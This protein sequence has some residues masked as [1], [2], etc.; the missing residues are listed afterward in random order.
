RGPG[1]FPAGPVNFPR[2]PGKRQPFTP[3]HG[4]LCAPP[5]PFSPPLPLFPAL[6]GRWTV[7]AEA[8]IGRVPAV[9]GS[10]WPGGWRMWRRPVVALMA[11]VG[12]LAV[13]CGSATPAFHPGGANPAGSAGAASPAP[14]GLAQTASRKVTWPPFGHDIHIV[15][16]GWLPTDRGQ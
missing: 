15:M 3:P 8:I 9:R 7:A 12:A 5:L 10:R 16:P 6:A 13:A 4:S 2:R 1:G 14:A 11:G